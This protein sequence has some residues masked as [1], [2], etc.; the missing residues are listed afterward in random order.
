MLCW[1]WVQLKEEME[2]VVLNIVEIAQ[3]RSSPEGR[4]E[5]GDGEGRLQEADLAS[6]I[7]TLLPPALLQQEEAQEAQE[8]SVLDASTPLEQQEELGRVLPRLLPLS[9]RT[10][11]DRSAAMLYLPQWQTC[12]HAPVSLVHTCFYA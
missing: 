9:I 6:A 5:G 1:L 12:C 11:C 10:C 3:R 8:D 7:V 4:R 2:G